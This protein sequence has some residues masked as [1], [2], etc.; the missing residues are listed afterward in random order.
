M[1]LKLRRHFTR[2][3]KLQVLAE[4]PAGKSPPFPSLRFD[5]APDSKN[6]LINRE[7]QHGNWQRIKIRYITTTQQVR[8]KGWGKSNTA[9]Q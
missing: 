6:S 7:N 3:F 1:T 5:I 8:G 4:I 9:P 2:E